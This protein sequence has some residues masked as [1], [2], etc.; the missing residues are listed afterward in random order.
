MNEP[1]EHKTSTV[2]FT[3][4]DYSINQCDWGCGECTITTIG[5]DGITKEWAVSNLLVM[6]SEWEWGLRDLRRTAI[7]H[8]EQWSITAGEERIDFAAT[9]TAQRIKLVSRTIYTGCFPNIETRSQVVSWPIGESPE[10]IWLVDL[11]AARVFLS[12]I[13]NSTWPID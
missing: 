2:L 10:T 7:L 3:G 8:R 6:A 12:E 5:D 11:A 1:C 9:I 13:R 4:T